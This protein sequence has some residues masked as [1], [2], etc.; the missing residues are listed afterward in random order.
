MYLIADANN[1]YAS[2]Q[3][4]FDPSL[5]GKPI[6]VLS[7]NDGCVI[8]RSQ[9]AKDLGI[10]M[11][12]PVYQIKEL[13][14]QAGVKVFSANFPLFGDLSLR[15]KMI[16]E[17]YSDSYE[18]YSI[19]E[20]FLE[21]TGFEHYDLREYA[22]GIIHT[23]KKGVGIPISIGIAPTKTLS[24]V[25]NKFAKKH[26]A[27]KGVCI[28]DTE[29]KRIKAL[30]LFEIEDVWGIGRRF[31]KKLR[32]MGVKTAYDFTQLPRE[33]VRKEM[34]V[35]GERVYRELMGEPSIELE[36]VAPAKQQIMTS[37]SFGKTLYEKEPLAVA[38]RNFALNCAEKLRKQ[39]SGASALTVFIHTNHFQ[40]NSP[41]YYN[42]VTIKLPLSTNYSPTLVAE[43]SRALD[44][45]YKEG[46]GY[47]KAGVLLSGISEQGTVQGNLFTANNSE[48]ESKLMQVSD[49]L[50]QKYGEI[51][52]KPGSL[53]HPNREWVMNQTM[54]SPCYTTRYED[55]LRVD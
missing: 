33:W 22:L 15:M 47:K 45:I 43:A 7:N 30:Q 12:Q 21:I 18:N 27:Y 1:F 38:V 54:L 14:Q 4:V 52:I 23:V 29:E 16:L 40:K 2:C 36:M 35:V 20:S 34:T 9:E 19:D 32:A 17:R 37:R 5:E 31:S 53:I 24:K 11:G 50:K 41:Q 8:A 55:L 26:K 28:I 39:N 6:V 13:I 10:K 49:L 48:K 51:L 42:S 46:Y 44:L 3:R 25:A